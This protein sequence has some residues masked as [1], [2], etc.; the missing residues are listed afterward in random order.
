MAGFD[1][2]YYDDAADSK[3]RL[4]ILHAM[5]PYMEDQLARFGNDGAKGGLRLNSI[6]RHMLGLMTG[7]PGARGFRQTLS[8]TKRLAAGD[9]TLLLEAYDRMQRIAA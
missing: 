7:L 4:E 3:T 6:T 9:P 2:R 8:D 1:A 5:L